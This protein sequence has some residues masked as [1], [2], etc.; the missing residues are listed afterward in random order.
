M[1]EIATS[2][3]A[4]EGLLYTFDDIVRQRA[5]DDD[6]S[7]LIA[8]PKTRS[9]VSDYEFFTGKDLN[10]LVDGAAKSLIAAGIEPVYES[11]IVGIYGVSDL[12]YAITIFGLGRLGYT[13]FLLSPRLPV[14]AC[15]GLL[16]G[17]GAT[18]LLYAPQFLDLAI[19]TS[20]ALSVR[21]LPVLT[22][23]EY[24]R[25]DD[26]T[27]EFG[28]DGVDGSKETLK[29]LI[30]MHSSG[31]TGLPRPI[32]YTHKRLMVTLLNAQ[33]M[34]AFQSVPLF[35]AHGFV[36]FIQAIYKRRTIYLFNG[37]VPQ[38]H[39]TLTAAIKA[40]KPELVWS[41]PY[42]LKLLAER[43]DG[44]DVLKSCKLVSCSG[45]RCPDDL[46]N[47]L[48]SQGIHLGVTFGATEV[49]FLFSSLN[50]PR[51]DKA[52][53]YMRA[54]PHVAP[55]IH[56]KPVDGKICECVVLDG[57]K[58][59]VMSNSNDPPN[60]YHTRDLFIAHD[61]IPNS[62]KFVGRLDDRV[63][64][65]NG[66]KVLPLPIEGR[67]QQHPLVK[68]AV[69]FGI[70][71]AVPGLLLFRAKTASNLS[72]EEF[73]E[74]VW[75][76]IED[77]NTHAEG[78]SQ[79]S[80][81]MVAVIPDDVDC[82]STDK[83][84]IKRAQ[85]YRDFAP[86]IDKVYIK[87]ENST[88]GI[89]KLT[90]PEL[91]HWIISSFRGLGIDLP[92]VNADFFAAGVDSLKAIQMRGLIVKE[93]D[94][95]GNVSMCNSLIVYY[96]GNAQKLAK[97]LYTIRTGEGGVEDADSRI[98]TMST[99]IQQYTSFD[100]HVPGCAGP[101]KSNVVVLTGA[102]GSLGSHIL[103]QLV[104]EPSV[105]KVYCLLRTS[106]S[107]SPSDRLGTALKERNLSI[108]SP[109]ISALSADLSKPQLSLSSTDYSEIRCA[110]THIIH[111]AWA[112]NFALPIQSFEPQVSGLHNLISLSLS[113][114]MPQP[115]H[116]LFCSSV[117]AAIN[118][119]APAVIPS[120][121]I[122]S[123]HH[124]SGTGYACS[125]LV[126]ERVIE[127]AV[128]KADACA[129]ILRI[130]QI[131][132]SRSTGSQLWNPT[133][134]IPLVVRS[135]L[136]TGTLPETIAGED[137]C[138]WLEVDTLAETI[139]E[140]AGL[141]ATTTAAAGNATEEVTPRLVYNLVNPRPFSWRSDFLP[142]LHVAGLSFDTVPYGTWLDQ[143][144]AS[145]KDIEKN[146]SRK[147]HRFWAERGERDGGIIFDTSDAESKSEALRGARSVIEGPLVKALV[148]AWRKV[149]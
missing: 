33:N 23:A 34:V 65:I 57:H 90:V 83:S 123:L 9:G 31:S 85:V 99:M 20:K 61:T 43:Q 63:T 136:T 100:N 103:A 55:F 73:V 69:V 35:H 41:V 126:A 60:S 129:T 29:K 101:A 62:W 105:G 88:G 84:S 45:S 120:S 76:A 66:E 59:K 79:I 93:L 5:I 67:I 64:L 81:E 86:I 10:R 132:P 122:L 6:Q 130:G 32:D 147:L 107:E 141:K 68:E 49:A 97:T 13:I 146:P 42:V 134:A 139:V 137:S 24:D 27:P 75:P 114:N 138:S 144:A 17:A 77:A 98:E 71:R 53:D 1:G 110:T 58:G 80:R 104:D 39:D 94:L 112:V 125:K 52:W 131:V 40:A 30:M 19:K 36:S 21:Y 82:P 127:A 124:S 44:I 106:P 14:N 11:T 128:A 140:L 25:P 95:G 8:Y 102:T 117:G 28:R 72:D 89:L 133:E 38:T 108:S 46:G 111:C 116:L 2:D 70:D 37:H 56:M 78:F 145:D 143:V 121:P 148:D 54:P 149:W 135:S 12:D 96:C 91:E 15:V 26:L 119:P 92:S 16:Q 109:K 4:K 51:E 3:S 18:A 50:R 115:A 87:L 113:V 118:T 22:R 74:G 7:P 47:L 48:V 142:S